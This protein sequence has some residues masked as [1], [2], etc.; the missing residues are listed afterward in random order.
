MRRAGP[1]LEMLKILVVKLTDELRGLE[2]ER[3]DAVQN[4]AF[5]QQA[6]A[7]S[8]AAES[9]QTLLTEAMFADAAAKDETSQSAS[10]K[11][12]MSFERSEELKFLTDATQTLQEE[13]DG[14]LEQTQP[15]AQERSASSPQT[16]ME[17]TLCSALQACIAHP[18]RSWQIRSQAWR[19]R[20]PLMFSCETWTSRGSQTV[21]E[22]ML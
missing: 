7:Q 8:A 5:I 14:A 17:G 15:L 2:S 18:A 19:A 12:T 1:S 4:H 9:K 3:W 13:T 21:A 11:G 16:T 22:K 6:K 20:F 10:K